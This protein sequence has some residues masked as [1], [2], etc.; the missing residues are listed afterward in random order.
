MVPVGIKL[1][2]VV[3]ES[4]HERAVVA[5]GIFIGLRVVAFRCRMC[6]TE[7]ISDDVEDVR[8]ELRTVVDQDVARD[9]LEEDRVGQIGR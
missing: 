6:C 2:D 4:C 7:V 5:L 1:S 9:G 8:Y 3:A